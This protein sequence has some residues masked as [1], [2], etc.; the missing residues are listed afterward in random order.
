M[1][2]RALLALLSV[3][4]LLA[5]PPARAD[6]RRRPRRPRSKSDEASQRFRSGVRFYKDH[7]FAAALVEF[8]Q[9]YDLVPNYI[10]L[11]NLGQTARELKDYAAAL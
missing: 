3:V 1:R 9:A 2:T 6:Q 5:G 8:K 10:V 7:D 4:A 11:Y